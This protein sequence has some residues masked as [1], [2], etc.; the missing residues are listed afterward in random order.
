MNLN[1]R[2]RE[3]R[4]RRALRKSGCRLWKV[5]ENSAEFSQYGP[6]A[7]V[8]IFTDVVLFGGA[9]LDS[10]ERWLTND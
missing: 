8:D 6:Y 7:V 3:R 4:I 9:D 10:V 1:T 2:N 5:R